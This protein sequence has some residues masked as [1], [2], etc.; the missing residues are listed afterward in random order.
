MKFVQLLVLFIAAILSI[1]SSRKKGFSLRD[2]IQSIGSGI[3][4]LRDRYHRNQS[5]GESR[6]RKHYK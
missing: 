5:Q 6:R 2:G 1:V 4:G 3:Q